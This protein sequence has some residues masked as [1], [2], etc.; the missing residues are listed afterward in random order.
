MACKQDRLLLAA[1][2]WAGGIKGTWCYSFKD[3][4][5]CE[6]LSGRQHVLG[7]CTHNASV[8]CLLFMWWP[9]CVHEIERLTSE[10]LASLRSWLFLDFFPSVLGGRTPNE[11]RE[12]PAAT[13]QTPGPCAVKVFNS[14]RPAVVAGPAPGGPSTQY[15]KDSGPKCH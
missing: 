9:S 2:L 11:E 7:P 8:G 5:C 14:L 3:A 4:W 6:R 13:A 12:W 1:K 10:M 15:L